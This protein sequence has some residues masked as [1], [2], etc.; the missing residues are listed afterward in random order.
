[1]VVSVNDKASK[2]SSRIQ[3]D[4][5]VAILFDRVFVWWIWGYLVYSVVFCG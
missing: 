2:R 3:F 4:S 1:M 5:F